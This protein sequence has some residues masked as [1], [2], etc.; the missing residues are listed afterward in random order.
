MGFKHYHDN[1]HITTD[2]DNCTA[3]DDINDGIAVHDNNGRPCVISRSC[4]SCGVHHI[5]AISGSYDPSRDDDNSTNN[6]YDYDYD[7]DHYHI[8]ADYDNYLYFDNRPYDHNHGRPNNNDSSNDNNQYTTWDDY[9]SRWNDY[10]DSR[11]DDNV[12]IFFDHYRARHGRHND[13]SSA[14]SSG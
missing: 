7:N 6:H 10:F 5:L 3:Y 12:A 4:P 2:Y 11:A 1:H 8:A 9:V 14:S 13:D